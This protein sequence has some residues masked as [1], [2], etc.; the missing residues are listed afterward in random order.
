M[1]SLRFFAVLFLLSGTALWGGAP[2]VVVVTLDTY[3]ADRFAAWGGPPSTAPHLNG[4]AGSGTAFVSCSAPAPVTLP[5]H[6]SLL[7]GCWPSRT[8]LHDNG[9]GVLAPTVP[10]LAEFLREKGYRCEAVVASAVLEG[11][12]G[13]SRGFHGYDDAVGPDLVRRAGEVTDRALSILSG[14]RAG[15]LFLWVHYFDA[16]EPYSSPEAFGTRFPG[17][18]YDAAAAYVDAEVGRLLSAL[19][20]GSL[21]AVAA[22]HGES[23]G[24]HGE[25]THGALLFEST[26]RVPLLFAGPGVPEGARREIPC[27]L[28]DVAPTLLGR[29][30]FAPDTLKGMDGADLFAEAA[31][32]SRVLL[33]ET[34]LPFHAFRWSPLAS[35]TDGRFKWIRSASKD[36]LFDLLGDPKETR[37]LSGSP[38]RGAMRVRDRL[39]SF[40]ESSPAGSVDAS[41]RG[42]GYAA[43]PSG[44]ALPR[45][46]PDPHDRTGILQTDGRAR[47]LRRQGDKE[48]SEALFRSVTEQDPGNPSGWFEYGETLRRGGDDRAGLAALERALAIA[49]RMAEAHAA[50]GHALVGLDRPEEAARCYEKAL[51]FSP[52]LVTALN[53]LAAYHLDRNAPEKAFPLLE[54]ALSEG[55]A[56]QDTYLMQGRIHLVQGKPEEARRDFAAALRLSP[57]PALTLKA[58]GDIYLTRNLLQDAVRT[59]ETGIRQFP[60]YAPNYLTLGAVLLQADRPD[61]ALAVFRRALQARLDPAERADVEQIVRDLE[62]A[63]PP[64]GAP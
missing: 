18:P 13:L 36:R 24:E 62:A 4:W 51:A 7:T 15:P 11:R 44:Q 46:L 5:S 17:H 10:V 59:F 30:G 31:A 23:L 21:V 14:R 19:S 1:R 2:D 9:L 22:D 28:V 34:W 12:Y 33:A 32:G 57:D 61:E 60:L 26:L 25:P 41:L 8:G 43:V 49:P 37:D 40:P 39:P 35:A 27:S 55:F 20:P 29:L 38:P 63:G 3:R 50:K 52:R 6:A 64:P 47:L 42:L 48:K 16:H 45:T 56:D 53:P 54:R 58:Q